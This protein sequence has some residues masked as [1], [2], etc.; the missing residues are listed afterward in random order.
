MSAQRRARRRAARAAARQD[1]GALRGDRVTLSAQDASRQALREAVAGWAAL[2]PAADLVRPNGA[3]ADGLDL[4]VTTVEAT[5][6][7]GTPVTITITAH[8]TARKA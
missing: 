7:G 8:I 1:L 4:P 3:H 6:P 5:G 2:N